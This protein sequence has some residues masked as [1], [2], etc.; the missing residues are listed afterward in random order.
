LPDVG[1]IHVRSNQ[2]NHQYNQPNLNLSLRQFTQ[3]SIMQSGLSQPKSTQLNS[4]HFKSARKYVMNNEQLSRVVINGYKSIVDCDLTL[5]NLNVLIGPNGAGKSN[6]IG[7]FTLVQQIQQGNLQRTVSKQGGPDSLLHFGRKKTAALD[8]QFFFANNDSRYDFSLAATSDNRMMFDDENRWS[9][10]N[11]IAKHSP[12]G[13]GHFETTSTSQKAHCKWRIYHFHDTSE[14]ARVLQLHPLNDNAYLRPDASNLAAYLYYLEQQ[15]PISFKKITKVVQLVA[16]FFGG[17]ALRPS[18]LNPNQIELEWTEHGEDFPF[19][20]HHLSDGTLRFICL[21]TVLMQ[22]TALQPETILIDEP[23]LGLHPYAITILASL[24]RSVSSQKQI[25]I[26]TQ[27]PDLVSE[28]DAENIIVVNRKGSQSVLSR[29]NVGQLSPWLEEYS[30]GELW[31]KNIL[32][33]RPSR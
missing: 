8:G 7:F 19:K 6:F 1:S 9:N 2:H 3:T 31:Q 16:P 26:C 33:G 17:F 27:S 32:G 20:A 12:L 14:S 10:L 15:Q 11:T 23:E 13:S 24:L 18:P 29:L 5:G 21:A 28:F 22:P 4:T 30:L 25:I